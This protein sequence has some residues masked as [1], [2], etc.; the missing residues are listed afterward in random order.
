MA[1]TEALQLVLRDLFQTQRYAVLATDDCGQPFTS[2]MAFVATQDMRQIII[3]TD[4][5]TRKFANLSANARV[6][7]LIDDRENKDSDTQDSVAVTVIGQ[8]REVDA[9]SGAALLALF[10][11]RHPQ[12]AEFSDSPNCAI[13]GV[14][15]DSYRLVSSF[16]TV[17]EWRVGD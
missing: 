7:L 5:T 16:Q 6:A 10:L 8:A 14:M 15:V 9:V 2:L 11:A 3:L 12:L 13:I 1:N 17:L 4:R